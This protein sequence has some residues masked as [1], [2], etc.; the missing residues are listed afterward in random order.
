MR[1]KKNCLRF[2]KEVLVIV[3]MLAI[4]NSGIEFL[5]TLDNV[6]TVHIDL[7]NEPARAFEG[8]N[9]QVHREGAE[10][11]P[12]GQFCELEAVICEGEQ[13]KDDIQTIADTIYGLESTWGK[14]DGCRAKGK[15]N[16]YGFGQNEHSWNCYDTQEEVRLAVE[17]WIAEKL[18][19]GHDVPSL[20]CGY[21]LG[22]KSTHLEECINQS[23]DFPYYK[24]YLLLKK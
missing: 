19:S 4:L 18:E 17:K 23:D 9:G 12:E 3:G 20:V 7:Q 15:F 13:P 24:N 5:K 6:M 21:N 11:T 10:N 22:F 1:F 8:E 2:A 16:G 14:N